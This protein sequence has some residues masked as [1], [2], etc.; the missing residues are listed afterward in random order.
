MR[1]SLAIEAPVIA[2]LF[3]GLSTGC[4]VTP[5]A[6]HTAYRPPPAAPP[7]GAPPPAAVPLPP[8]PPPDEGPRAE[9]EAS[10]A[11]L[12]SLG[13]PA[14]AL[15]AAPA[16]PRVTLLALENTARGEAPGMA[17][18]STVRG[19]LLMEGQRAS[20]PVQ[21]G[22][23]ECA[24]FIAQGGLGVIEL[25]L[26]LTTGGSTLVAEDPSSGP[27]AV[28]GG[29]GTCFR[30]AGPF[31]GELHARVRRGGGLVIVQTYRR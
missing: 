5:G 21:V 9:P 6:R 12:A 4:R 18:E 30:P 29:H 23:G 1:P 14:Q 27:I 7:P 28:L 2:L 31:N 20:A 3:A 17:P 25:D 13:Q 8:P 15:V 16:P 11:F 26:F 19:A 22:A 10:R 24:T